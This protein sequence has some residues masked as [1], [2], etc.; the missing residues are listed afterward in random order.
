[1]AGKVSES[2]VWPTLAVNNM[3]RAK[4]FYE[5]TLGYEVMME[6]DDN[7][8]YRGAEGTGLSLYVSGENAGTNKATYCSWKVDDLEGMMDDLRAKGVEFLEYDL[9]GMKTENGVASVKDEKTGRTMKGT[10][11]KDP[12]GNILCLMEM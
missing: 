2:P 1:M 7:V 11:F 4:E 5:G 3:K 9:P 8:A 6:D 12:D 10:W